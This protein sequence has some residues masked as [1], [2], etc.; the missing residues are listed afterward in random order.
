MKYHLM[1][2]VMIVSDTL[3]YGLPVGALAYVIMIEPRFFF[4][5]PYL[6]RVPSEQKEYWSPECDL[7]SADAWI[8]QESEKVIREALID[9][10]LRTGNKSLFEM[11]ARQEAKRE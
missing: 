4:G 1:Q 6:I 8:T 5:T 7:E 11:Q 9:F 3:N 2:P 10:A